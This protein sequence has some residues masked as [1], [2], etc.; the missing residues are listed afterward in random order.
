MGV[1]TVLLEKWRTARS[2]GNARPCA[3]SVVHFLMRSVIVFSLLTVVVPGAARGDP[4][5]ISHAQSFLFPS[6][7]RPDPSDPSGYIY[8][9]YIFPGMPFGIYCKDNHPYCDREHGDRP[10]I[11][12]IFPPDPIRVSQHDELALSFAGANAQA[13]YA[14]HAVHVALVSN[15]YLELIVGAQD[16]DLSDALTA[17]IV[18]MLMQIDR[19]ISGTRQSYDFQ[20]A[21]CSDTSGFGEKADCHG[22]GGHWGDFIDLSV[23]SGAD[24]AAF[25]CDPGDPDCVRVPLTFDMAVQMTDADDSVLD[26]NDNS[27]D[28]LTKHSI[29][30]GD[31]IV[32]YSFTAV[33]EPCTTALMGLGLLG[34]VVA[35]RRRR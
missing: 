33:P 9:D 24:L 18:D 32:T 2:A 13:G 15:Y 12:P 10:R 4:I 26:M 29:W 27:N 17:G 22:G 1:C 34:V 31:L 23:Y 5:I 30:K 8:G 21:E 19:P 14:L 35:R 7:A 11:D 28:V 20:V 3:A 25:V 6:F 16:G